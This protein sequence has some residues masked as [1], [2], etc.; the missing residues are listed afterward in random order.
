M[1]HFVIVMHLSDEEINPIINN[2]SFFSER[3]IETVILDFGLENLI[4]ILI[5]FAR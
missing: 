3:I 4:Y 5:Y 2:L 1:Y